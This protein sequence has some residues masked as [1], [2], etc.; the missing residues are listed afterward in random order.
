MCVGLPLSASVAR[1]AY[2]PLRRQAAQS[3]IMFIS[4]AYAYT[5]VARPF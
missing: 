1:G 4:S 2:A 3:D 5:D